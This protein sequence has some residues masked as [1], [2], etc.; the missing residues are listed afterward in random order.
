MCAIRLLAFEGRPVKTTSPL[1]GGVRFLR[2]PL[3]ERTCIGATSTTSTDEIA[4]TVNPQYGAPISA[5]EH[6]ATE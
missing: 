5:G 4:Q 3:V 1:G 2:P 6:V